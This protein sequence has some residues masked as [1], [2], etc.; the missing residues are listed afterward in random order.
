MPD[1]DKQAD[2]NKIAGTAAFSKFMAVL[3]LIA[4]Q[5]APLSIAQ[6]AALSGYPRPTV[7]RILGALMA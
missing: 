5:E 4:D 1:H 6:L 2:D 3:Q 7:Y